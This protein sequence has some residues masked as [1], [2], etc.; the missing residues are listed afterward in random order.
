MVELRWLILNTSKK[1]PRSFLYH[2]QRFLRLVAFNINYSKILAIICLIVWISYKVDFKESPLIGKLDSVLWYLR[3]KGNVKKKKKVMHSHSP[4]VLQK[5]PILTKMCFT[6]YYLTYFN[7]SQNLIS[8]KPKQT[9]SPAF[10]ST[11]CEILYMS[12]PM[13]QLTLNGYH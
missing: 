7:P 4:Y 6:T 8:S 11:Y 3:Y 13:D 10:C 2:I 9:H 5:V 1:K 12:I